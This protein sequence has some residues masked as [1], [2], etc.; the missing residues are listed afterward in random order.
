MLC[1]FLLYSKVSQIF[2]ILFH[3][4]LSQEIVSIFLCSTVGP[5][6]YPMPKF[7]IHS[8]INELLGFFHSLAN[9]NTAAMNIGV[10][11]SFQIINLLKN[12]VM[13]FCFNTAARNRRAWNHMVSGSLC[14]AI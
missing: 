1:Q 11:V 7:F 12:K 10:H 5:C 4:A 13:F 6:S 9:V 14:C 2:Y 8:S 3:N